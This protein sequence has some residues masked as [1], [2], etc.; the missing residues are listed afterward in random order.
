[1]NIVRYNLNLNYLIESGVSIISSCGSHHASQINFTRCAVNVKLTRCKI[2]NVSN[3][4]PQKHRV[5]LSK[6]ICSMVYKMKTIE[7]LL[8]FN[9]ALWKEREAPRTY[10]WSFKNRKDI[11]FSSNLFVWHWFDEIATKVHGLFFSMFEQ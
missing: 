10:F 9:T 2:C 5:C 8:F 3:K 1:M 4:R 6:N 7:A 11:M